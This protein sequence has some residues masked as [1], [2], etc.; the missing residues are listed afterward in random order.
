MSLSEL[1]DLMLPEI[2]T[3]LEK[4]VSR[5]DEPRTKILHDMLTYH[6]GWSGEGS[7][8]EAQGKR[9]R[10]LLVLLSC[11][12]S[13][14]DWKVALPAAAAAELV[15]N[16]SLV[17]DD[18]QDN[19][20]KRRGRD[21]VWTK[22]GIPQGINAGD[23]LFVLSNLA[24]LDLMPNL[25]ADK[26]IKAAKFLHTT[27]LELTR[28]QFLDMS[29]EQLTDVTVEDYWPMVGAKTAALLACC[30]SLGAI[31]GKADQETQDAYRDF[32]HYLGLAFQ[33]QD[34]LLGIWGDSL[35]TGKSADSD[36][37]AKKKS[38]PVIYGLAKKGKFAQL[39]V[40]GPI[41]SEDVPALAN[42]LAAEGGRLYTQET[43]DQMTDLAL[44]ALREAEPKGEAGDALFELANKLLMRET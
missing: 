5:L 17:H 19:S 29:Y 4:Q 20:N 2:E 26:V 16:F 3:E 43:A 42:Q 14:G 11:E 9:I 40:K 18:I 34:D 31:I 32:G 10:P 15:H 37:I 33:V 7:G 13:H 12:A 38:L 39:W 44:G 23:A 27:C 30:C 1:T 28:G 25:P 41:S 36:L 24:V 8:K 22:W 35:E 6:M 21:T